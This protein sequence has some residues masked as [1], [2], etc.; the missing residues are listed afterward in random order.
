MTSAEGEKVA[1]SEEVGT[2]KEVEGW[3]NDFESVM[4]KTIKKILQRALTAYAKMPREQCIPSYFFYFLFI[5]M[6]IGMFAWPAQVVL[7]VNQIVFTQSVNRALTNF[8]NPTEE[9]V[10]LHTKTVSQLAE[11]AVLLRGTSLTPHQRSTATAILVNEV[12]RFALLLYTSFS[13]PSPFLC[14]SSS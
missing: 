1:L 12:S 3:L 7:A 8:K 6:V 2:D 10:A 4:R 14:F 9:F 11:L 5:L 13:L